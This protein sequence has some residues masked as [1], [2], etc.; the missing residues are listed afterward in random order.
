MSGRN[1]RR[2][3][4]CFTSRII[5]ILMETI[6]DLYYPCVQTTT[7]IRCGTFSLEFWSHIEGTRAS[8][9]ADPAIPGG[10]VPCV[11][12]PDHEKTKIKIRQEN[13]CFSLS[14]GELLFLSLS[15]SF[16]KIP[17]CPH[18][19]VPPTIRVV[20]LF[21]GAVRDYGYHRQRSNKSLHRPFRHHHRDNRPTASEL[22]H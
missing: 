3:V 7:A 2:C 16:S 11:P 21:G 10:G 12:D 18:H 19:Y 4:N 9:L 13:F 20:T 14:S 5:V 22:L 8:T 6:K 1:R 15:F 17:A